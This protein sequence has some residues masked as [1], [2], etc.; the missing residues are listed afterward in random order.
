M[1]KLDLLKKHTAAGDY[2]HFPFSHNEEAFSNQTIPLFISILED[3]IS[4]FSSRFETESI[5]FLQCACEF[6]SNPKTIQ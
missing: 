5:S 6:A 4:E 2:T 3:L 1:K